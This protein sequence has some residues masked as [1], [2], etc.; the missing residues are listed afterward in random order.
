MLTDHQVEIIKDQINTLYSTESDI[1]KG[2][3]LFSGIEVCN[4]ILK[5]IEAFEK[6]NMDK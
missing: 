4:A 3:S 6:I 2:E 1:R 5:L